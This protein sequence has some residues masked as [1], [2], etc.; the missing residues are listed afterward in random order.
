MNIIKEVLSSYYFETRPPILIDIGASGEINSKWKIIAKYSVC[1]CFDADSR[2][3]SITENEA[4]GYKKLIKINRIVSSTNSDSS[5]FYLTS[6]PY[7][8]SSLEPDADKL[9]P[10]FFQPLF[11]VE[12]KVE[13]KP[14][15][16]MG[17][18]DQ[19]NINYIDWFKT[20]TQGTDLRL[21]LT[22]SKNIQSSILAAEFEPGIIDA[23]KGEDKLFQIMKELGSENFWLSD[24]NVKGTKRLNHKFSD[25]LGKKSIEG[26]IRNS[27]CWAEMTYLR[28]SNL[29]EVRQLLLLLVFALIEKQYGFAIEICE[30]GILKS[31]ESLF[32]RS[33]A[34]LINSIKRY[35]LVKYRINKAK[36]LISRILNKI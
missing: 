26:K 24:L 13:L 17:A 18:L 9:T 10:W 1:L 3:F 19:A 34:H 5:D 30:Q 15:T 23:Y 33:K 20:D 29:D 31:N 7:C 8:S 35:G 16:I 27:P 2:E 14:I 6:S 22:L 28:N 36:S 11:K 21:F 25:F 32:L 12:Q 4:S